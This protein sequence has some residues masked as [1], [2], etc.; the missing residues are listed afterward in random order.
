MGYSIKAILD[1][2]YKKT[3]GTYP[4]KLLVYINSKKVPY[5]TAYAL[6]E[7]DWEKLNNFNESTAA[8]RKIKKK[9]DSHIS[10]ADKILENLEPLS[11]KAF[12]QEFFTEVHRHNNK[13]SFWFNEYIKELKTDNRPYSTIRIYETALNS[14]EQFQPNLTFQEIT[15][16]FID[17]YEVWMK[18]KG[19]SRATLGIYLRHLRSIFNYAIHI[20][21]V[22]K[23]EVHPFGKKKYVIKTKSRKKQ[24]LSY[25]QIKLIDSFKAK[26]G[27]SLEYARDMWLFHYLLNGS[28][29]KDICR[30]KYSDLDLENNTFSFYRAKTE[31]T[32]SDTTPISGYLHERAIQIIN[33]YGNQDK[34]GFVFP[35]FNEFG[36]AKVF[37]PKRE[38][39]IIGFVQKRINR[40]LTILQEKLGLPVKLTTAIARH[41]FARKLNENFNRSEIS[42]QLGHQSEKTTETYINSIDFAKK[43]QMAE[44]LL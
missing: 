9:L 16:D 1:K 38:R 37:D 17:D 21:K 14:L 2:R 18:G 22:I 7:D 8:L 19:N 11:H 13:I 10:N 24:S 43:Q 5:G 12:E 36:N 25:D 40:N 4:V 26:A 6:T 33:R 41:S 35:Y 27:S 3:D 32:E 20:K 28:N 42:D 23:P 31:N 34:S 29:T 30:L 44:S 15:P 39:T